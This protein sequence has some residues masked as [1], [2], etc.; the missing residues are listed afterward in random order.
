MKQGKQ[1]VSGARDDAETWQTTKLRLS[2]ATPWDLINEAIGK[3]IKR[4]VQLI[5][6][7]DDKATLVCSNL[8]Q[9]VSMLKWNDTTPKE[10]RF[11]IEG[12]S[13]EAHWRTQKFHC[14]EEWL[15]VEGLPY[16]IWDKCIMDFIGK[17]YGGLLCS[18][19]GVTEDRRHRILIKWRGRGRTEKRLREKGCIY[20]DLTEDI[21]E[22]SETTGDWPSKGSL[23]LEA[24]TTKKPMIVVGDDTTVYGN[25]DEEYVPENTQEDDNSSTTFDEGYGNEEEEDMENKIEGYCFPEWS[26]DVRRRL[27]DSDI[28]EASKLMG[29]IAEVQLRPGIEDKRLWVASTE[30]S[31]TMKSMF[32]HLYRGDRLVV[33]YYKATWKNGAPNKVKFLCWLICKEHINVAEILQ[34][35]LSSCS[36]SPHCCGLWRKGPETIEHLFFNC[37]C[38]SRFW[39]RF[40]DE[41]G[42][43][44]SPMSTLATCLSANPPFVQGKKR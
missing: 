28:E 22:S 26:H 43:D 1:L 16:N 7:V 33:Q 44:M 30:G 20:S 17:H 21:I 24:G 40:V 10:S 29:R 11:H 36:L 37:S 35:R 23:S 12:W 39:D 9:K 3:K 6:F 32:E 31:F 42:V 8:R 15:L 38:T 18:H 41:L 19:L 34:R 2:S 25:D 13:Q 5:V 4:P 14:K 27:P